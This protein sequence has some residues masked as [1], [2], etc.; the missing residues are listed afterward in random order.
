MTQQHPFPLF[1]FL[2]LDTGAWP[3][4]ITGP[5]AAR[6]QSGHPPGLGALSPFL[7]GEPSREQHPA[8]A[9]GEVLSVQKAPRVQN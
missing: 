3:R 1:L 5:S 2:D 9:G 7:G 8:S 6:T 4:A